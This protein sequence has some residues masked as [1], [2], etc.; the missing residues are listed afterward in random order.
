MD[1]AAEMDVLVSAIDRG[2][3][4]AAADHLGL[5]PSAVS[6]TIT[7]LEA[8][9]GVKLVE[10]TTRRIALTP[11]GRTFYE[12][13]RRIIGAID[14]AEA[15]VMETRGR[16]QGILRV[17][18]G[19]TF[20][21][22]ELAPVLSDF[23]ADYPD[24]TLELD[25]EDRIA[26]II[27]EDLDIGIRTGPIGDERLV[28]RRFADVMRVIVASPAYLARRGRPTHPDD[29]ARHVCIPIATTPEMAIWPFITAGG[30]RQI[31]VRGPVSV[32]SASGAHALALGGVGIAR[33][34]D[35]VVARSIREGLL[36]PLFEDSH[37]AEPVPMHLVFPPGRQRLPKVRAF[38]DFIT[39][40]FSNSPWKI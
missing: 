12:S 36:V 34:G 2:G 19:I 6:K 9:L 7:R 13:A 35:L 5:T 37:V 30:L 33:L 17:N 29:L 11:E 24:I 21:I 32:G 18:S 10:R 3:F 16:P 23:M 14:D 38:L 4:T 22:G 31:E 15:S 26:D 40:R 39:T 8:R 28:S 27:G 25:I 1:R 20:A